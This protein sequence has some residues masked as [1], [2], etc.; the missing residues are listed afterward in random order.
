MNYS[1]ENKLIIF[2][3]DLDFGDLL[4][5]SNASGPSVIQMHGQNVLPYSMANVVFGAINQIE[6]Q[7]SDG[8]FAII[9]EKK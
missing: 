6:K 5:Y 4:A 9:D 1:R 3:N 8:A 7:L 2:T